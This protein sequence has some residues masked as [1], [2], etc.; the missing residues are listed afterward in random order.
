MLCGMNSNS[1]VSY[2]GAVA[3]E[4]PSL[5]PGGF[6][7]FFGGK[8]LIFSIRATNEVADHNAK[9]KFAVRKSVR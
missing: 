8:V 3:S 6:T 4:D 1:R 7:H 5:S 9:S 2:R